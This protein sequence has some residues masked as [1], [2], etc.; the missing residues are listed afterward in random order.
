MLVRLAAPQ[1]PPVH[2]EEDSECCL[3]S[4]E[5]KEGLLSKLLLFTAVNR[6]TSLV[7]PGERPRSAENA[8]SRLVTGLLLETALDQGLVQVV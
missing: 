6:A 2:V 5:P 1:L 3:P 7:V 8:V 4:R